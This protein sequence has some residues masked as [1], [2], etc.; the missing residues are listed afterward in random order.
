MSWSEGTSV[1]LMVLALWSLP[2]PAECPD[3][4]GRLL[5]HIIELGSVFPGALLE[6]LGQHAQDG[7]TLLSDDDQVDLLVLDLALGD[8]P[9]MGTDGHLHGNR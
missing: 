1:P 9:A 3:L 4:G 5:L 6:V 7:I 8:L 2:L